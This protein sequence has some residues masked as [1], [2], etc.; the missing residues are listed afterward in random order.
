MKSG[1][2]NRR[3]TGVR[4]AAD[5]DKVGKE[6]GTRSSTVL[7]GGSLARRRVK[8]KGCLFIGRRSTTVVCGYE[9]CTVN[10]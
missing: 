4:S 7:G 9:A 2:E 5:R 1:C 3:P 8:G 10:T 6:I